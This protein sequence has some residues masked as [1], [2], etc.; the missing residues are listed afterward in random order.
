MGPRTRRRPWEIY[1]VKADAPD[2]TSIHSDTGARRT[3]RLRLDVARGDTGVTDR[4]HLRG[5]GGGP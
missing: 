1:T 4:R 3:L 2:A 5:R